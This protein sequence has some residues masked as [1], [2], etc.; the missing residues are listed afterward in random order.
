MKKL[1]SIRSYGDRN[2]LMLGLICIGVGLFVFA[3][4]SVFD[5]PGIIALRGGLGLGII[6]CVTHFIARMLKR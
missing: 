3:L 6:I 4:S 5:F 1:M 2:F